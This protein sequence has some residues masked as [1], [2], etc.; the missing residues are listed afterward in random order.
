MDNVKRKIYL[1]VFASPV[2]LLPIVV[3][4]TSLLTSWAVGGNATLTFAGV[5]GIVGGLGLFASR[6]IFGLERLTQRA[7]QYVLDKQQAEQAE[8]LERLHDKLENDNDPRTQRLLRQMLAVYKSL[9]KD[10]REGKVTVA[11]HDV[12][13]GVDRMFKVCVEYL[14]R[15][16]ELWENAMRLKGTAKKTSLKQR[17]ELVGEVEH[18][19]DFLEKKIDQLHSVATKQS[20]SA[21]AD[22]R[23]ELDETIRVARRAEQRMSEFGNEVKSH[24]ESEFE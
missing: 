9:E 19:V 1:D 14:E 23:A 11:A 17:D 18:S 5:A 13:D 16:Y 7:Y 4:L 8:S 20:K 24:D 12:L 6:I 2:T 22:L 3:G 15:S 21:L 10:V